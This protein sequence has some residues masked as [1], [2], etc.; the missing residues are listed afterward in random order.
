MR[1]LI[2]SD[3][4]IEHGGPDLRPLFP[5][6]A[7]H[8]AVILAGDIHKHTRAVAWAVESFPGKPVY[9]VPGNH[10]YY[11]GHIGGVRTEIER[12][13]KTTDGHVRMLDMHEH[14][15]SPDLRILGATLWTDF[16]LFVR[17]SFTSIEADRVINWSMSEAKYGLNDFWTIRGS[18]G[19]E[20]SPA[21]SVKLHRKA[22]TFLTKKLSDGF[23]GKTIVVTHHL[24]SFQSVATRF[25]DNSISPCFASRLDH[26]VEKADL[27][28]H[29]HTHDSFDYR[30]GKCRV[31]CNPAGYPRNRTT[32]DRENTMFN[33]RLIVE[34]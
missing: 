11:D 2:L 16:K 6:P 19:N 13:A 28:I 3:L 9:Y 24:P 15:F 23:A 1:F 26:L 10:E 14:V 18:R 27:W 32:G 22:V 5:D 30:I 7:E 17:P 34:V 21:D 20:F 8:D 4:H 29:G 33:P 31:V 12:V 25:V